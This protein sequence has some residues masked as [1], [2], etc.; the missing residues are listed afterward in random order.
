MKLRSCDLLLVQMTHSLPHDDGVKVSLQLDFL[1]I[2]KVFFPLQF[3]TLVF[4][5]SQPISY[6][7]FE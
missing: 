3:V 1:G 5:D 7:G 2:L 4:I 6:S